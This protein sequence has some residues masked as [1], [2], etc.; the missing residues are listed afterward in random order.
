MAARLLESA[1]EGAIARLSESVDGAGARGGVVSWR[2]TGAEN[3]EL[4][5]G[6]ASDGIPVKEDE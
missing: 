5:D 4:L 1:T 3:S 6:L 2:P